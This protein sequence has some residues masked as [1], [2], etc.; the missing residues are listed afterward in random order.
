M[1]HHLPQELPI[2]DILQQVLSRMWYAD[3]PPR[4]DTMFLEDLVGI[5]M[6]F[7]SSTKLINNLKSLTKNKFCKWVLPNII[8]NAEASS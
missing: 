8:K 4:Q 6:G 1:A 2:M 3:L 7:Q 5:A